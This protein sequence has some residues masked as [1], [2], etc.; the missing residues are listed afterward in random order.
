M[1]HDLG[2]W[3]WSG[4]DGLKVIIYE[5]KL[6]RTTSCQ[7]KLGIGHEPAVPSPF[8]IMS[9]VLEASVRFSG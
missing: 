6:S 5:I 3:S 8:F 9:E 7:M 4:C 2:K 1:K